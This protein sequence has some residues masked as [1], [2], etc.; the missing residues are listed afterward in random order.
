[1]SAFVPVPFRKREGVLTAIAVALALAAVLIC[2][3]AGI[4]GGGAWFLFIIVGTLTFIILGRRHCVFFT[5]VF[6][7]ALYLGMAIGS[8]FSLIRDRNRSLPWLVSWFPSSE[9]V[10]AF[11]FM[12]VL[13]VIVPVGLAW[14]ITR[15]FQIT[16]T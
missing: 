10:L 7:G 15:F 3:A 13:G 6:C 14:L 4:A 9:T 12:L 5:T 11:L 8:F 2:R 1:M 16:E